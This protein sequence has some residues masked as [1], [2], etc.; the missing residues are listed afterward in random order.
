MMI[1]LLTR[2]GTALALLS[3]ATT[4][5]AYF[6]EDFVLPAPETIAEPTTTVPLPSVTLPAPDALITRAQLTA[7]IVEN[8]YAPAA[9]DRC[10]WDI[11]FPLPPRF[12]L[13]FADVSVDHPYAKHLCI[14]MRD[15]L[16]HGY[17]DGSFRPDV[18]INAAEISKI[19]ARA[20]DLTPYAEST[21]YDVWSEPYVWAL[22]VRNAI[23]REIEHLTQPVTV[24]VAQEMLFRLQNE[25]TN[26]PART[27]EEL[28]PPPPPPRPRMSAPASIPT[29]VLPVDAPSEIIDSPVDTAD[30]TDSVTPASKRSFWDRF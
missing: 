25:I 17:G 27:Y 15:G 30:E 21:Q 5:S 23:P 6:A 11:G 1:R 24:A 20:Y 12:T 26:Q 13:V 22:S 18:Q 16:I 7:M 8:L 4:A 2:I 9:I 10:Y 14:A 28:V 19:L 3:L 29:L